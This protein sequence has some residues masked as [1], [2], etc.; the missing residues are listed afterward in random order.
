MHFETT[1]EFKNVSKGFG[2]TKGQKMLKRVELT[3]VFKVLQ[4]CVS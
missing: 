2:N 1:D 3:L 4:V